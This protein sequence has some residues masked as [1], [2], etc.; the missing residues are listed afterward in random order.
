MGVVVLHLQQRNSIPPGTL[1]G[2]TGGEIVRMEIT[3]KRLR[4]YVKQLLKMC[5]LT[6]VV[7]QGGDV[8]QI[9]DML[10]GENLIA[11]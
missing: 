11:P 9:A 10:G 5:D 3:H 6:L 4:L 2:I 8:F 7:G 1:L